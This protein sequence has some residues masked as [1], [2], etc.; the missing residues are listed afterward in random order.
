MVTI[1]NGNVVKWLKSFKKENQFHYSSVATAIHKRMSTVVALLLVHL[2]S[3]LFICL[4]VCLFEHTAMSIEL[5]VCIQVTKQLNFKKHVS[6][7]LCFVPIEAVHTLCIFPFQCT[8]FLL[9]AT[10]FVKNIKWKIM[11]ASNTNKLLL[12]TIPPH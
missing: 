10:I 5:S 9:F 7:L 12:Q 3:Y 1:L 6:K 2:F 4:L 11:H 8:T